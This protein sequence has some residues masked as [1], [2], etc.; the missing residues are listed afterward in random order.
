[1]VFTELSLE[2]A[3]LVNLDLKEDE[4]GFFS[5][6]FCAREFRNRALCTEWVQIN[7]SYSR[8]RG[9]LRGMHLQAPPTSEVKLVRCIAGRVWDCIVDLR[10]NS[11]TFGRYFGAELSAKNR[12][13]MYVPEGFAHG[14]I[15]LE[16]CSELIYL[17]SEYYTPKAERTLVWNDP[18]VGIEWPIAPS[19]LSDKDERGATLDWFAKH[20]SAVSDD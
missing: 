17:V 9:T 16:D 2:G 11:P 4:R 19:I 3:F 18:A 1:M 10:P 13:M 7:N 20:E 15:T 12:T 6:Y 8:E 5:R 14:F